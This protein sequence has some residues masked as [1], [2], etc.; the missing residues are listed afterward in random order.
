MDIKE[1]KDTDIWEEYEKGL[2]YMRMRNV[3]A[4]TDLNYRMYNGDQW[5]GLRVEGIEPV[6]YNI[7][8]TIVN[9]KTSTINENLW[10]PKFSS[11][12]FENR[13]F[14]KTAERVCEL[15]DKKAAKV[16]EKDQMDHKIREVSDDSCINDEGV[17]YEQ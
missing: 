2:N 7:I 11:E 10:S 5:Y 13:D 15:L 3:F 12:N 1:I 17:M 8:E 14:R 16:W 4:D 6:Q 9:Y